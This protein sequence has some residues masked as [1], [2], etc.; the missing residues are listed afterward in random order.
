[1]KPL[2]TLII[3]LLAVGFIGSLLI[4][5]NN[6]VK[7]WEKEAHRLESEIESALIDVRMPS[8]DMEK[9]QWSIVSVRI[10]RADTLLQDQPLGADGEALKKELAL[11]RWSLAEYQKQPGAR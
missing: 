11:A 2:Q 10:N 8:H 3:A 1:M 4:G 6:R 9:A 5:Q 7:R